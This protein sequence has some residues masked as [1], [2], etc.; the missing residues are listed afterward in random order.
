MGR[1]GDYGAPHDYQPQGN[2]G[3]RHGQPAVPP[4]FQAQDQGWQAAQW[5]PYAPQF[6]P[7]FTQQAQ[8]E[9]S[10]YPPPQC[11]PRRSRHTARNVIAGIGGG[12]LGISVAANSGH[13]VQTVG[14][15][16]GRRSR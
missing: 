11:Q 6:Q 4:Q 12:V 9:P 3:P 1:S 14:S 5:Q 7:Q 16:Q 8:Y 13:S 15:R 2:G 10:Q